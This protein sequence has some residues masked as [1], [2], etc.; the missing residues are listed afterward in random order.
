VVLAASRPGPLLRRL[1]LA[2][3]AAAL[4]GGAHAAAKK[5][6]PGNQKAPEDAKEY[7]V[8]AVPG[9]GL[10]L[11]PPK[12][13][14]LRGYTSKAVLDLVPKGPK[15]QAAI[16]RM[17]EVTTLREFVAGGVGRLREWAARQTQN[18][19]VIVIERGVM[20]PAD[21][22][23]AV[24]K[25]HFQETAPGVYVLRLPLL[26]G[27]EASFHIDAKTKEFRLSQE[28]G[29]FLANDGKLFVTGT[30][31]LG[32]REQDNAPATFRSEQEFR[33]YL[34]SW[35]G[36][37]LYIADSYVA[38]FGYEASKAY[39]ISISQYSPH[40]DAML[41]QPRPS[42]WILHSEFVDNW[43]AFYCYEAD[44]VAVVGNTYRDNIMYG[45]D[46]H[47]RSRRLI[48]AGN[49]VTGTKKKH[50]I[51]IS[52]EVDDSWIIGNRS[53][54]NKLSGIVIDRNSKNNVIA[55]NE[56]TKN[57]TDGI[58]IYESSDN[59][60]WGNRAIG[61]GRHGFRMRNS[62]D[63]RLYDNVAVANAL[64]G[65]YG[66][67]KDLTGTDRDLKLDPFELNISMIIVGGRLIFNGSGP[68]TIDR[69]LSVELY[70]VELLA[71][72]KKVG[73]QMTGVLG[74]HQLEILDIL[75][76][77][78]KAALIEPAD[79][80]EKLQKKGVKPGPKPDRE[81]AGSGEPDEEAEEPDVDAREP[82]DREARA[83][84]VAHAGN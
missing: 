71:P 16:R 10:T 11:A 57:A 1:L 55:Y 60:L 7:V 39:G 24:D 63:I 54:G 26:V 65:I 18:P 73:I 53:S 15:G 35:G 37:K 25:E 79:M 76:R 17:V 56:V 66:H 43:Y 70:N 33:P 21:L 75:V 20:T 69:P 36:A 47:D 3:L 30:R 6:A 58:T 68:V 82:G 12:L 84:P 9:E 44:D 13:P 46:P 2:A 72:S 38:H 41:K 42:G 29:A 32:W 61:N 8:R 83:A 51:I 27:R 48:I 64:A 62:V 23:K 5:P 49:T 45:I 74:R 77:Q 81:P 28:R 80:R 52:R 59:L 34:I 19:R 40:M 50:G 14:D 22:A 67:I 31:L 78:R 4:C